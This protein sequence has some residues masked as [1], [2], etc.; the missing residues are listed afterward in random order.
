MKIA[1]DFARGSEPQPTTPGRP[2]ARQLAAG[3]EWTVEDVVCTAGPWDRPFEEMH[4]QVSI[5]IVL[6]GTFQYRAANARPGAG[7]LMTP[8]SLMLG[9]AGQHFECGHEHGAGDRCLSFTFAPDYFERIAA[10]AGASREDRAFAML[11]LPAVRALSPLVA[12]AR[13]ALRCSSAPP[14]DRPHEMAWEELGIQVAARALR[15]ANSA[16]RDRR[17][18]LPSELARV[19]RAVRL[20]EKNRESELSLARMAQEARLSPYHFLRTFQ[21]LTGTTPHQYIRRA[22]LRDAATRLATERTK[23][24]DIAFDSGFGDISNFN[25]AFRAEFGVS[26]RE[27]RGKHRL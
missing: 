6:E 25:H 3:N 21:Q 17:E 10:D 19:T 4:S 2:A 16:G 11:R 22:R 24:L 5:A 12:H 20:I 9:N 7:T 14:D 13:A 26:P 1:V 8:G 27:F 18:A 23:V 15:L